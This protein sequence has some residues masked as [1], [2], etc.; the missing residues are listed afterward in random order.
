MYRESGSGLF[1]RRSPEQ[2]EANIVSHD[3]G[4]ELGFVIGSVSVRPF[5]LELGWF[6]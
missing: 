5:L 2:V 3:A 4:Q 1:L 6:D